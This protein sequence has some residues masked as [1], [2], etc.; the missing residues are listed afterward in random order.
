MKRIG[1]LIGLLFLM[2]ATITS[3]VLLWTTSADIALK[4]VVSTA[5]ILFTI[6]IFK[7]MTRINNNYLK[8][9][10]AESDDLVPE[11]KEATPKKLM[12][13]PKCYQAFDGEVCF[14]CGYVKKENN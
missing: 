5:G 11:A 9:I 7:V 1:Y 14:H 3:C 8:N 12:L 2:I 10:V 6:V 13:C 4:I